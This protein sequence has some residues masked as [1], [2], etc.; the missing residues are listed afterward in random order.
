MCG[1]YLTPGSFTSVKRREGKVFAITRVSYMLPK[2]VSRSFFCPICYKE[3]WNGRC[4][5]MR[6]FHLCYKERGMESIW[7]KGVSQLLQGEAHAMSLSY[8]SFTSVTLRKE[9]KVFV[10]S[11]GTMKRFSNKSLDLEKMSNKSMGLEKNV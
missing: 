6:G 1:R 11:E 4:C 2:D 8:K 9:W 5:V 3:L 7:H 10:V